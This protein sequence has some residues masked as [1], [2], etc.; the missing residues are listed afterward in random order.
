MAAP[1]GKHSH[2]VLAGEFCEGVTPDPLAR[3]AC[4]HQAEQFIP[5]SLVVAFGKHSQC[6]QRYSFRG[7][8]HKRIFML[9][10]SN[11]TPSRVGTPKGTGWEFGEW[12]P[13]AERG[14][15]WMLRLKT[16]TGFAGAKL[17]EILPLR[18]RRS[19]RSG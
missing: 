5:I 18:S 11:L 17:S 6:F 10:A 9:D 13:V 3:R 1:F 14:R 2:R 15:K 7:A 19:L 12:E 8:L 16:G 4:R